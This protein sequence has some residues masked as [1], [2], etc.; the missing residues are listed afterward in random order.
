MRDLSIDASRQQLAT[1]QTNRDIADTRLRESL[2]HTTAN[3]KTRVL[4][5]RVGARQ[6]RRAAVGAATSPQ[7]LVRVNKAKV[8]VGQSPPLDLVSAQAEVAANQEQLIIARDR[9]ASRP[10]IG[11]AC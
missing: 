9:G 8:D 3:V 7:E 11:C 5:S 1:S 6:R 10:R 4:E 2:V